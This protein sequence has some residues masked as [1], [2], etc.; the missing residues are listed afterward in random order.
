[1][2][3]E[4]LRAFSVDFDAVSVWARDVRRGENHRATSREACSAAKLACRACSSSFNVSESKTSGFVPG[5][6]IETFPEQTRMI[7]E[8]GH[9]IG[10][11]GHTHE[12]PQSM[13]A[14][15]EEIALDRC[16][17]L[18]ETASGR[19]PTGYVAPNWEYNASTLRLLLKKGIKYDHNLMHRDFEPYYVRDKRSMD[20]RG[21]LQASERVMKP[22]A[23]GRPTRLICLPGNGV[24]TICRHSCFLNHRR[25]ATGFVSP[26]NIER[27]WRDQFDWVYRECEYAI[28][29]ISIHPDVSGRPE[30]LLM[31]ERL[32]AHMIRHHSRDLHHAGLNGGRFR[33]PPT[34]PRSTEATAK[35]EPGSRLAMR[36]FQLPGRSPCASPRRRS[37]VPIPLA[38]LA[39]IETARRRQCGRRGYCCSRCACGRRATINGLGW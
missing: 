10:L 14:D 30:V 5:H 31:L 26:R 39:G 21:L 35:P 20:G 23:N 1:M 17:E 34:G 38:T 36:D 16:I 13:T 28:F 32:C 37:R 2:A 19:R 25:T 7:V 6:S 4:L 12:D 27:Q 22:L 15:Q 24:W 29:I 8:A 18:I 11:H 33:P 9:E 3:K